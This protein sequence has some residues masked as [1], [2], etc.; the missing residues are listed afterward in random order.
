M[1]A[2]STHDMASTVVTTVGGAMPFA[3]VPG[4][5]ART[6]TNA[7]R[8]SDGLIDTVSTLTRSMLPPSSVATRNRAPNGTTRV[9]TVDAARLIWI[10]PA[11]GTAGCRMYPRIAM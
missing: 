11:A 5:A 3:S 9:P 10:R 6:Y 2:D 1:V 8:L 4:S 7:T